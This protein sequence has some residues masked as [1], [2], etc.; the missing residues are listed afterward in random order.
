MQRFLETARQ[1]VR[2]FD[3]N[4]RVTFFDA[5]NLRR[6][7]ELATAIKLNSDE[8]PIVLNLL[9]LAADDERSPEGARRLLQTFA[10]R[11][12]RSVV[13]TRG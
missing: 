5:D 12:L 8:L 13:V 6:G 11:G 3:V 10:P 1:A 7:A 9:G 4:L 2:L